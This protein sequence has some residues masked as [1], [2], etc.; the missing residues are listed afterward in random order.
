MGAD[1]AAELDPP[2]LRGGLLHD[3]RLA[4]VRGLG[5]VGLAGRAG[6][7]GAVLARSRRSDSHCTA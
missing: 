7:R 3:E 5:L 2:A 6:D 4:D 1:E